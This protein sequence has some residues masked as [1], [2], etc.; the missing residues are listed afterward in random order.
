MRKEEE[1]YNGP[2]LA[3]IGGRGDAAT[4]DDAVE[5]GL[6]ELPFL[7][8]VAE[9]DRLFGAV[10]VVFFGVQIHRVGDGGSDSGLG[11]VGHGRSRSGWASSPRLDTGG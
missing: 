1:A 2:D 3:D 9:E 11:R 6:D 7:E 8:E 4:G 5:K 10:L